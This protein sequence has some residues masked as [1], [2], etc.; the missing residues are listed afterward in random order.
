MSWCNIGALGG[1]ACLLL[2]GFALSQVADDKAAVM[3]ANRAR[4]CYL[5]L[6][7]GQLKCGRRPQRS[8]SEARKLL[9]PGSLVKSQ[10]LS[11]C[12]ARDGVW[13][14]KWRALPTQP[15]IAVDADTGKVINCGP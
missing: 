10:E 2:P 15:P 7:D 14:Y 8:L 11:N 12:K 4:T 9:A 6:S 3:A 13:V 5:D 1:A